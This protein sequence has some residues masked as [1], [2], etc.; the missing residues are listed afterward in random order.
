MSVMQH[1]LLIYQYFAWFVS[2]RANLSSYNATGESNY[3]W[4][5]VSCLSVL[6]SST[7]ALPIDFKLD[8]CIAED[9]RKCSIW[10]VFGWSQCWTLL[11]YRHDASYLQQVIVGHKYSDICP[12]LWTQWWYLL[13]KQDSG[14]DAHVGCA[15]LHNQEVKDQVVVFSSKCVMCISFML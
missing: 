7:T 13:E 4:R 15:I 12:P 3:N 14:L 10:Y 2:W 9:P 5:N 8:R 6:F 1:C 11:V